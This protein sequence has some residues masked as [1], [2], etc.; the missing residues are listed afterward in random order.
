MNAR[1]LIVAAGIAT[2]I[3]ATI[4]RRRRSPMRFRGKNVFITGGS[5]GLGLL[6]AAEFLRAGAN[7]AISARDRGELDRAQRQLGSEAEMYSPLKRI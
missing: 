5:R 7:V 3:G 4:L 1:N 2:G 6:L